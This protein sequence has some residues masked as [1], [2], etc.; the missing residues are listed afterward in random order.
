MFLYFSRC[1]RS[2]WGGPYL[3]LGEESTPGEGSNGVRYQ[4]LLDR[5]GGKGHSCYL[6]ACALHR[7]R[8]IANSEISTWQPKNSFLLQRE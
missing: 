6:L 1:F 5:Y 2:R 3:G 4:W 8:S 7:L